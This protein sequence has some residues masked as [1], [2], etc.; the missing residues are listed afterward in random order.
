MQPQKVPGHKRHLVPSYYIRTLQQEWAQFKGRQ[1]TH[2]TGKEH[3]L[4]ESIW[5]ITQPHMNR[6]YSLSIPVCW[7]CCCCWRL[8]SVTCLHSMPSSF[9]LGLFFSTLCVLWKIQV[10]VSLLLV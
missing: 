3:K 7:C 8:L 10:P 4:H 6:K 9:V 2:G 1:Q 5:C